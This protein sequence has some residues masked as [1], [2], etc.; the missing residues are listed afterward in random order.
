MLEMVWEIFILMYIS[1]KKVQKE[2]IKYKGIR[3]QIENIYFYSLATG[4]K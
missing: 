2:M 1:T 4:T 3:L